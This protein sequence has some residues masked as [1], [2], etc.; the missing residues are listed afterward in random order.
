MRPEPCLLPSPIALA[1]PLFF[2][3]RPFAP[4]AGVAR[5]STPR[6]ER[7]R[8][9]DSGVSRRVRLRHSKDASSASFSASDP[10]PRQRR[11]RERSEAGRGK[12]PRYTLAGCGE[13]RECGRAR[14]VTKL[15]TARKAPSQPLAL[16]GVP[17]RVRGS[18]DHNAERRP[19]HEM[20]GATPR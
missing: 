20:V 8:K 4:P 12:Y 18:Q 3:F 16:R 7:R 6:A 11:E 9:N 10:C 13:F 19:R 17:A 14:V 15:L 5:P 1:S 2:A